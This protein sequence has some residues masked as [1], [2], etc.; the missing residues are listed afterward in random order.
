M[1]FKSATLQLRSLV[2]DVPVGIAVLRGPKFVVEMANVTYLQII[3][4]KEENFVGR[5]LFQGL[6]EVKEAVQPLLNDVYKKGIPFQGHEFPVVI[7]RHGKKEIAYFDFV[8]QPT[9]N[10]GV[11][12][13]IVVVANE[14]T[15]AVLAK[16]KISASERKFREVVMQSPIGM[17]IILGED[18]VIDI[19]NKKI[20]DTL[21]QKP[22][23]EV[24]G[25][26]L[27][28]AFPELKSQRFPLMLRQ[29]YQTGVPHSER[30]AIVYLKGPDGLQKFYVDFIYE[31]LFDTSQKVFG[32]IVTVN[33]VTKR[34][35]YRKR[36][37]EAEEKSR[38]AI[39]SAHLG[40]YEW[41]IVTDKIT[42]SPRLLE[43][44][45]MQEALH[46]NLT[47]AVH[48]DD[49]AIRNAAHAEAVKTGHLH[50]EVRIN[51]SDG[52]LVWIRAAGT[53]LRNKEGKS[54][55]LIGIVQDITEEK[56]FSEELERQVQLRTEQLQAA[57]EEIAATN[58]DLAEANSMLVNANFEL[59]QFNYAASHDLQE[60]VR[61][62]QTFANYLLTE[63]VT[64]GSAKL[65]E[66]LTKILKASNRMK[67]IIDDL[68]SYAHNSRTEKHFVPTD[69]NVVLE[70]VRTDLDLMIEQK[71]AK[72]EIDHMPTI[73]A[74]PAQMHQLFTNLMSNS[75][76]FTR[77]GVAPVIKVHS[78][79]SGD[80]VHITFDDN[81]LGFSRSLRTMF[82]SCSSDYIRKA[83]MRVPVLAFHFARRSL[84]ITE[85]KFMRRRTWVRARG[86]TLCY[87]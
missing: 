19:A 68:L 9:F 46:P 57:N 35:E 2:Q 10:N 87:L 33:D 5:P 26:K 66:L 15:P 27:I 14:V 48:P 32:I 83:N 40:I 74:E 13:G 86:C 79:S 45:G 17:A 24:L 53:V 7:I 25:K 82:S 28:E 78:K 16:Q 72:V 81:G 70:S 22:S 12:D 20:L 59:E 71:H 67:N 21:W 49:M 23:D 42:F 43:I 55:T 54:T 64:V 29:V 80:R 63:E 73:Q 76:K 85:E 51:R 77:P 44:F 3:D 4:R 34:V 41:D 56:I 1:S 18:M 8:Y 60:P 31:P 69:L 52:K 36:I 11:I 30:E 6:P 47:S 84:R 37:E 50:Y 39:A 65:N 62:I 61:K 75:L 58:E 38:L